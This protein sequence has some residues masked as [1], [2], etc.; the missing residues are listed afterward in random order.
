[1]IS[2]APEKFGQE[3][4]VDDGVTKEKIRELVKELTSWT[5]KH[6]IMQSVV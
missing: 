6:Q 1:M 4:N 2:N 3:G 5:I